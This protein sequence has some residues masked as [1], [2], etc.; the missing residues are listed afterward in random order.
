VNNCQYFKLLHHGIIVVVAAAAVIVTINDDVTDPEV[1]VRFPALPYFFSG[2][3]GK[4]STQ[5]RE[6]N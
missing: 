5:P 6:Y 3:S 1:W 2:V 4:G